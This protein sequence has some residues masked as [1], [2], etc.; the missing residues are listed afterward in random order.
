MG[1]KNSY[2]ARLSIGNDQKFDE[3][4]RTVCIK[5]QRKL[6]VLMKI[7]KYLKFNKLKILF[8]TFFEFRFKCCPLTR[9]FHSIN[10]IRRL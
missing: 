2:V 3:H 6:I 5:A 10:T 4:I 9:M 7:R 8:K 1:I